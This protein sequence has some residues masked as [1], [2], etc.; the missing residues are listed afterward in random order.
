[1]QGS[2]KVHRPV[3]VKDSNL[4]PADQE[5]AWGDAHGA[6]SPVDQGELEPKWDQMSDRMTDF[7]LVRTADGAAIAHDVIS[8]G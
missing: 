7:A 1:L 6:S 2:D 3:A 5:R 8:P 4:G